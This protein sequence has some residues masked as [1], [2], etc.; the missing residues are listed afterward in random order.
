MGPTGVLTLAPPSRVMVV[1][2][3]IEAAG[4]LLAEAGLLDAFVIGAAR[5][6]VEATPVL[7]FGPVAGLLEELDDAEPDAA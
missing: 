6:L 1:G 5:R 4:L 7:R 2:G 3:R